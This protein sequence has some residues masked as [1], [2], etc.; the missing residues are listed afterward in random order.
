MFQTTHPQDNHTT[1]PVSPDRQ[2]T[3]TKTGTPASFK[4]RISLS[5]ILLFCIVSLGLFVLPASA[6]AT[7]ESIIAT[8]NVYVSNVSYDPGAFFTDDSGTVTYTV[9]N[10][11]ANTSVSVNHATLSDSD[12]R[13]TSGTYDTTSNIG[14]LQSRTYTFSVVTNAGEG[15]YYPTFSLDFRD[16]N[17]LYYRD[18]VKVDNT[19]L[20]LTVQDKPDAFTQGKKDTISVQIANPRENS[21]KNVIFS[22]SGSEGATITP[23]ETYIGTL[24]AGESTLLNFTVMPDLKT[25]LDLT[26]SY[27]NGDNHHEVS[28]T[29]PISFSVNKQEADPV[30]SNIVVTLEN[31]VYT[32]TGDVT[33]AG[34]LTAN[35]VTVSSASPAVAEDPYQTYVIGALKAD[36][37]GSFQVTF[38]VPEGT[39]KVPLQSSY[40]DKDGNLISTTQSVDLAGIKDSA[41]TSSG[42]GMMPAVALI[43]IAIVAIGGYLYIKKQKK[44]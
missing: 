18:L 1:Q 39:T 36:D 34:L 15:S 43:L 16:G 22:V 19:P 28:Q 3:C 11:N 30:M 7:P 13:L 6:Y 37:F 17:S 42:P 5:G 10:G 4:N 21:V 2:Y 41:S 24:N 35:G 27:D 32:V 29:L 12:F 31:G 14:P 25:N 26:V 40:K 20:V 44:Q 38:S 23:S 8:G 33:N 9:A